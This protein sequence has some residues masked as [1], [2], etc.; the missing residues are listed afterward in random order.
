VFANEALL[1]RLRTGARTTALEYGWDQIAS[2][3]IELMTQLHACRPVAV[4]TGGQMTKLPA[5]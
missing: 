5:A 1:A 2:R 3:Y 4:R